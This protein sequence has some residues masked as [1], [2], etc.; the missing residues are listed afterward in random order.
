MESNSSTFEGTL[1]NLFLAY[2][3]PGNWL[4]TQ[5]RVGDVEVVI[6]WSMV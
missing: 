1:P 2:L 6:L 3:R 4:L 5:A